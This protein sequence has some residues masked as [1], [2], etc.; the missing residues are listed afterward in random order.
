MNTLKISNLNLEEDTVCIEDNCINMGYYVRYTKPSDNEFY[1]S[2]GSNS[3]Y[4]VINENN[5][6]IDAKTNDLMALL[7]DDDSDK[8]DASNGDE[9]FD[10][11]NDQ[12]DGLED[13]SEDDIEAML[14][15]AENTEGGSSS[16]S[17]GDV[18]D[19]VE[20]IGGDEDTKEVASLLKS[21]DD[22][23][24]VDES[25]L[26][27][28]DKAEADGENQ[29][30]DA[31]NGDGKKKKK[32]KGLLSKLFGKKDADDGAEASEGTGT[33][34]ENAE[35]SPETGDG[36]QAPA[37]DKSE[38]KE[39]KPGFFTKLLNLL[40]EEVE[41]EISV[42]EAGSNLISDE[43]KAILEELD[44]EDGGKKKKKGKKGKGKDEGE[45]KPK[46]EKKPKAPKPKK[47]KLLE[48]KDK[49]KQ[50]PKKYIMASV[51]VAASLLAI[52]ILITSYMPK[53]MT[54]QSARDA[55]YSKDYKTAFY[56]LYGKDLNE[57]DELIYNKAKTIILVERK[58]ESFENYSMLG[59][60][61]EALDA[62]LSGLQRYEDLK[63]EATEYNVI[64]EIT[65][66]RIQILNALS[67]NFGISESE[68]MSILELDELNYYRMINSIV[69]GTPYI[70]A[71]DEVN[72]MYGITTD[73]PVSYDGSSTGYD[74]NEFPD[75]LPEEAD[76]LNG[77]Y[78][79]TDVPEESGLQFLNPED[80]EGFN[81]QHGAVE[82]ADP[83]D[84]EIIIESNQF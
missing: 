30:P 14:K 55:Y 10:N 60:R 1:Y 36:E 84:P 62:L 48:P 68:A 8:S 70:S 23:E 53:L 6:D 50:I 66:I 9:G 37:A 35:G 21:V 79:D 77:N 18:V 34:P 40:T 28:L 43:N 59:M 20:A 44:A 41:E 67:S 29:D 57:S 27:K 16:V 75:L 49:T 25:F 71:E 12:L 42:P 65:D 7:L 52:L 3:N 72:M 54:M 73:A 2:L 38:K 56:T 13:M 17:D 76:Y 78:E 15:A 47:E 46:K 58:L 80:A 31:E 61:L 74:S 32:K 45:K 4:V 33:N 11:I 5:I 83:I 24:I 63:D 19:I 69:N 39:K 81:T 26:D 51:L 22:N 82:E 64:D